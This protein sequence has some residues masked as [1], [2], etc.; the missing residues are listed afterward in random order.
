M[1]LLFQIG[2]WAWNGMN[3]ASSA[4]FIVTCVG[5]VAV[6]ASTRVSDFRRRGLAPFAI[7]GNIGL[8]ALGSLFLVNPLF[9]ASTPNGAPMYVA[10]VPVNLNTMYALATVGCAATA[11]FTLNKRN[12]SQE[13][14]KPS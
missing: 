13:K 8:A 14:R 6:I 10:G 2:A 7:A 5:L 4:Y 9:L 11:G 3:L 12:R 1:M